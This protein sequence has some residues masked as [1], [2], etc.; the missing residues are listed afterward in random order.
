[1]VVF[2]R[3]AAIFPSFCFSILPA[4]PNCRKTAKLR[5]SCAGQD[6][7][8]E[9]ERNVEYSAEEWRGTASISPDGPVRAGTMGA[10]TVRYRT[11]VA[12]VDEGG[13]IRLAWRSVSDWP[14]PQFDDPGAANYV[15]I[16]T[17]GN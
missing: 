15:S 14:A 1:M 4:N 2:F 12:G 5:L 3:V 13:R 8:N 6:S 7:P 17:S 11:G 10:W 16:A 9:V